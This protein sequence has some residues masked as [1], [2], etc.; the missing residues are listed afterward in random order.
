MSNG[1]SDIRRIRCITLLSAVSSIADVAARSSCG[2]LSPAHSILCVLV[3]YSVP[4]FQVVRTFVKALSVVAVDVLGDPRFQIAGRTTFSSFTW[5]FIKRCECLTVWRC[6]GPC[7][8]DARRASW[9]QAGADT[10]AK[11]RY[12]TMRCNSSSHRQ[13][14]KHALMSLNESLMVTGDWSS[15]IASIASGSR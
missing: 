7:A 1:S 6:S 3:R 2:R 8:E 12:E 4:R 13:H 15:A 11:S 14:R 10:L 9:N 5:F